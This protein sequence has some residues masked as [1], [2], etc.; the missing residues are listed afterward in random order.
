MKVC[1]TEHAA[2]ILAAMA[3]SEQRYD[4]QIMARRAWELAEA[5]QK[6]SELR[7]QKLIS[8]QAEAERRRRRAEESATP[9]RTAGQLVDWLR[10]WPEMYAGVGNLTQDE[11]KELAD[12][13]AA[14]SKALNHATIEIDERDSKIASIT[15][16]RNEQRSPLGQ[17]SFEVV[18]LGKESDKTGTAQP[19]PAHPMQPIVRVASVARFKRNA[20]ID[21]LFQT[22]KI[23]LNEIAA[24]PMPQEDRDQFWQL[25]G[26]SVSSYCDLSIIS[27]ASKDRATAIAN[28]KTAAQSFP[29]F[30]FTALDNLTHDELRQYREQLIERIESRLAAFE[31]RKHYTVS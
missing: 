22:G 14:L 8:D 17:I 5:F 24:T 3:G 9:P 30:V 15:A 2:H 10:R 21:W 7:Q 28:G 31:G 6:E 18:P 19:D 12:E 29:D 13:L 25:L 1:I 27:D 20:I 11:A 23:S 4:P 26:Y 16:D